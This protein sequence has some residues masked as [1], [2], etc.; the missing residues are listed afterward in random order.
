MYSLTSVWIV[1]K[2]KKF[3]KQKPCPYRNCGALQPCHG[4]IFTFIT[5][6]ADS[7]LSPSSSSHQLIEI[8]IDIDYIV[9]FLFKIYPL[10]SLTSFWQLRFSLLV[11]NSG[12]Y[13]IMTIEFRS[14]ESVR[15]RS[16][17]QNSTDVIRYLK[18][19]CCYLTRNRNQSDGL[20]YTN[21]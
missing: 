10:N 14:S 6:Q 17:L 16:N 21:K 19:F 18:L 1:S 5:R 12:N 4:L 3:A 7:A 13:Q 20:K 2:R 11:C 15:V 8:D 9:S